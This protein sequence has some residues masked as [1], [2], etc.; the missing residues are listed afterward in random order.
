MTLLLKF[1]SNAV[2]YIQHSAI[3]ST[4][5]YSTVAGR[6]QYST[7]PVVL[8]NIIQSKYCTAKYYTVLYNRVQ[9]SMPVMMST[10][11]LILSCSKVQFSDVYVINAY[12]YH[13]MILLQSCA[14]VYRTR[15][16]K[17]DPDLCKSN[18][19]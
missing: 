17:R 3:Y 15:L 9:Y 5:Q 10:N 2:K 14:V 19:N 13:T 1:F 4:V 7:V 6:V 18:G 16:H 12:D 8:Y 11:I